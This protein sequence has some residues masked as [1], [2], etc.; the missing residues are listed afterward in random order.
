MDLL[1][2]LQDYGS[3]IVSIISA[4][5][6]LAALYATYRVSYNDRLN[7]NNWATYEAYNTERV[8]N[9]RAAARQVLRANPEGFATVNQY[10]Q[11]FFSPAYTPTERDELKQ[12]EQYLHDLMAFYHQVG[13]LLMKRQ[14]DR[15]FILLML[16]AG[17]HDRWILLGQVPI[18]YED[19]SKPD[20]D[21]PYGGMYLLHEAYLKWQ[22]KRFAKLKKQ[23]KRALTASQARRSKA[24]SDQ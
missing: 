22:G 12:Q 21:F 13:L 15:D 9:G 17:V 6:A 8:R 24:N 3:P 5:I 4:L 14:V 2:I 20:G 11:Y 19:T 1:A 16:G 7:E 18:F 23:F 10:Y